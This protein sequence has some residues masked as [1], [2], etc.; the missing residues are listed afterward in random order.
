MTARQ[1]LLKAAKWLERHPWYRG[2]T[3]AYG[4]SGDI[5]AG[6]AWGA[7][8]QVATRYSDQER[9]RRKFRASVGVELP[10]YNDAPD[11]RK[12]QVIAAMRRAA[13]S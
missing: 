4:A 12:Y 6:C 5:V 11:R 1:V 9:A 10:T 8:C 3:Y 2:H 13:L 7:V